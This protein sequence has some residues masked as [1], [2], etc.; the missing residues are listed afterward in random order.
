MDRGVC[1]VLFLGNMT[2]CMFCIMSLRVEGKK[3][4]LIIEKLFLPALTLAIIEMCLF[5][6]FTKI[7]NITINGSKSDNKYSCQFVV[8]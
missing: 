2:D 3:D 7:I 4:Q 6:G 8:V 1:A 5:H